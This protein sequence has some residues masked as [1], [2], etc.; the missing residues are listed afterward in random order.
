MILFPLLFSSLDKILNENVYM[1]I[2]Y[3]IHNVKQDYFMKY[4]RC[5]DMYVVLYIVYSTL[6]FKQTAI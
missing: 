3:N 5:K 4:I 1:Y 2:Q 6:Q